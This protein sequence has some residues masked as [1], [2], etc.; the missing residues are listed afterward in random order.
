[1]R[2][3]HVTSFY[4][5][6]INSF[7]DRH[8]GL[9]SAAFDQQQHALFAECFGWSDFVQT[10]LQGLGH[11]A[12]TIVANNTRAQH[13]W[14]AENRLA[15]AGNGATTSILEAQIARYQ[16]DVLFFED[17]I[18]FPAELLTQLKARLSMLRLSVVHVGTQRRYSRFLREADLIVTC[19]ED[20]TENFRRMGARA[21]TVHHGFEPRVLERV[22]TF[23]HPLDVS[24]VGSLL[25]GFHDDRFDLLLYLGDHVDVTMYSS[26][27]DTWQGFLNGFVRATLR[28]R[29][30]A[31]VRH[32]RSSLIRRMQP[33]VYGTAMFDVLY[34][35]KIS[36]NSH[37]D[38][39]TNLARNMRLF[40]APQPSL[41]FRA[42]QRNH[43][44]QVPRRMPGNRA[45]APGARRRTKP[46]CTCRTGTDAEG[47]HVR[48]ADEDV[49]GRP[50]ARDELARWTVQR[51]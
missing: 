2:V 1:M 51:S 9:G 18:T 40:E 16:P 32:V 14:A 43:G 50:A 34:N 41:V 11:E 19:A 4:Q 35:S 37:G 44:I 6:F 47:P 46:A 45:V 42:R 27:P 10:H 33:P 20:L 21:V 7:Y 25:P 30:Q 28:G 48:S 13:R 38:A 26:F 3:C 12:W 17:S 24:F 49:R 39:K 15:V 22:R 8:P 5:G 31:F 29:P 36:L 23:D